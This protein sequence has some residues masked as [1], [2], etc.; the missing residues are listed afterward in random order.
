MDSQIT[1]KKIAGDRERWMIIRPFFK[2]EFATKSDDKL[3][4]D[5]LPH[6]AMRSSRNIRDCFGH[7]NK[8]NCIILD[9]YKGYTLMPPEPA[10]DAHGIVSLAARRAHYAA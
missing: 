10:P 4:L 2:E 1:L 6:M 7:L 9:A 5:G 3:I 8:V